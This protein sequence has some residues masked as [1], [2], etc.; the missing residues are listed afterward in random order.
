MEEREQR[1]TILLTAHSQLDAE[2]D[3]A[4]LTQELSISSSPGK[5]TINYVENPF[6]SRIDYQDPFDD[7]HLVRPNHYLV[8]LD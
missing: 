2:R 7:K 3:A 1:P 8:S 4:L 6:A 5:R